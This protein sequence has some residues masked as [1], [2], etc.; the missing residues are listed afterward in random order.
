MTCQRRRRRRQRQQKWWHPIVNWFGNWAAQVGADD[1]W[2]HGISTNGPKRIAIRHLAPPVAALGKRLASGQAEE[3]GIERTELLLKNKIIQKINSMK[4]V[5]KLK[6]DMWGE[7]LLLGSMGPRTV[8]LRADRLMMACLLPNRCE[9]S[10]VPW[11][12]W[13]AEKE[14]KRK[15]RIP[16]AVNW[17]ELSYWNWMLQASELRREWAKQVGPGETDVLRQPSDIERDDPRLSDE[18]SCTSQRKRRARDCASLISASDE[19]IYKL[20]NTK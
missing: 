17:I 15:V 13:A 5:V 2:V 9:S 10:P 7:I 12:S 6:C 14:K 20:Q 1:W 18:W 4:W 8:P 19:P 16:A 11:P 3:A